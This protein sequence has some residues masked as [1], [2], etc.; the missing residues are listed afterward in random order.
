[1]KGPVFLGS[2]KSPARSLALAAKQDR[3]LETTVRKH[4]ERG[5]L[6]KRHAGGEMSRSTLSRISGEFS[7]LWGGPRRKVPKGGYVY[8]CERM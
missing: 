8:V 1:M 4:S 6:V 7:G 3:N 5:L 2:R